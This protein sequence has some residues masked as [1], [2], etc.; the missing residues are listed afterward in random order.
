MKRIIGNTIYENSDQEIIDIIL[1]KYGQVS[2]DFNVN[3]KIQAF[4]DEELP[5]SENLFTALNFLKI[6]V[7]SWN[8]GGVKPLEIIDVAKW[9]FPFDDFWPDIFVVG[10]QEIVPLT[11]SNVVS[12]RNSTAV[13]YWT[14]T[15]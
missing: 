4:I 7:S 14:Q 2:A 12:N 8:I 11:M 13:E 3:S 15:I 1:G 6:N 5:A 9:L 10:F